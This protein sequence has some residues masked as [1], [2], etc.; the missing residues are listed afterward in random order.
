[1][2]SQ[3][4]IKAC[5]RLKGEMK[6]VICAFLCRTAILALHFTLSADLYFTPVWQSEFRS[7][8]VMIA[9]P[10]PGSSHLQ[11]SLNHLTQLLAREP[12]FE[13]LLSNP[14]A[15]FVLYR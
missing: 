13:Y 12:W 1:M 11:V 4:R 8:Q 10:H 6:T 3:H 9:A 2:L 5:L 7:N 15:Q 14:P